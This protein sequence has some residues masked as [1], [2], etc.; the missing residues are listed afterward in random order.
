MTHTPSSTNSVSH[1]FVTSMPMNTEIM[2]IAEENIWW[3][4]LA[5][6]LLQRIGIVGEMAHQIAVV[7]VS[8]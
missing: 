5:E 1:T 2:V 8:K 7:C 6:H 3:H 4:G